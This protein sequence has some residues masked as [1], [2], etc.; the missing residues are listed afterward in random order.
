L[1][2]A[3]PLVTVGIGWLTFRDSPAAVP[4]DRV[5]L[6]SVEEYAPPQADGEGGEALAQLFV[7]Y[8]YGG[9]QYAGFPYQDFRYG[10]Y[11]YSG[12]QYSNQRYSNYR[13]S[14]YS[15]RNYRYSGHR[16]SNYRPG[17]Y[18][19]S[20]YRYGGHRYRVTTRLSPAASEVAAK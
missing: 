15:Y 17:G 9:Y 19:Y 6:A 2:L 1:I 5:A 18:R 4:L 12:Y 16:Y 7:V 11:R 3:V 10:S 20:N 14:N 13:Y 8:R